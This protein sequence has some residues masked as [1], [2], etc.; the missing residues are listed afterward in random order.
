MKH[1]IICS[2]N[3]RNRKLYSCKDS[4]GVICNYCKE[5]G[6]IE[7]NK[8]RLIKTEKMRRKGGDMKITIEK[9][10]AAKAT[11]SLELDGFTYLETWVK[12][13]ESGLI[14]TSM[15]I[16]E[17]LDNNKVE[18]EE[19]LVDFIDNVDADMAIFMD[20]CERY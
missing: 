7:Y 20:L 1:C 5:H 6:R 11:L 16:V 4:I 12:D 3:T 14:T 19:G 8:C 17:Q 18:Y 10:T 2:R 13:E 15:P 9:V